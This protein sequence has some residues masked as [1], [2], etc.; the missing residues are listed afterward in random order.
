MLIVDYPTRLQ[1]HILVG[2]SLRGHGLCSHL[3]V[4]QHH[5]LHELHRGDHRGHHDRPPDGGLLPLRRGLQYQPGVGNT[6][7][8]KLI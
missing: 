2:D 7:K 1:A 8:V 6:K 4:Q 3:P 5:R